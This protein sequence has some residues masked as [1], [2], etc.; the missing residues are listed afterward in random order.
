MQKHNSIPFY[1]LIRIH[2]IYVYYLNFHTNFLFIDIYIYF[3]AMINSPAINIDVYTF[4]SLLNLIQ[5][6]SILELYADFIDNSL[7][8][9]FDT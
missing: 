8:E 2:C 7:E 6:W 1:G 9:L 4:L 3:Q 5:V